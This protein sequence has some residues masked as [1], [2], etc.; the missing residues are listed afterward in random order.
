[1]NEILAPIYYCFANDPHPE[2]SKHAEADSFYCFSKILG[3]LKD[4]FIEK[5][6]KTTEGIKANLKIMNSKLKKLDKQLWN[7]LTKNKIN[8]QYYALRWIMLGLT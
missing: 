7:H 3:D 6:D 2:F 4:N 1:M 5:M 8:P